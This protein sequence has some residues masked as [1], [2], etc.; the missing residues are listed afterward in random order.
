M[1][2]WV[3]PNNLLTSM[4]ADDW[5]DGPHSHTEVQVLGCAHTSARYKLS[6]SQAH[7]KKNVLSQVKAP[8]EVENKQTNKKQLVIYEPISPLH[9]TLG[10]TSSAR[11]R[12]VWM[13]DSIGLQPHQRQLLIEKATIGLWTVINC[14]G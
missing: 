10:W 9:F 14:Y 11:K 2:H 7:K 6:G 13:I 1:V 5:M 12:I 8:N 4:T 3:L